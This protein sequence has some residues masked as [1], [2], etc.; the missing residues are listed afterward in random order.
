M[1]KR[2]D[3]VQ[4][5]LVSDQQTFDSLL[6]IHK[7]F[8]D[9]STQENMSSFVAFDF[10]NIHGY[11]NQMLNFKDIR[12]YPVFSGFDAITVAQH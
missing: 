12:E 2:K 1:L 6:D 11:P 9:P 4:E 7:L 8:V 10:T 3:R 5:R